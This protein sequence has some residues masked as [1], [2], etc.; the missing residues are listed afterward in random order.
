MPE[1]RSASILALAGAAI[2][3]YSTTIA[4]DGTR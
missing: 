2:E 3:R 1:I 4:L